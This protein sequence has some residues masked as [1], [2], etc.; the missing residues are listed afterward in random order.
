MKKTALKLSFALVLLAGMGSAFA[1]KPPFPMP[2][3][4]LFGNFCGP[5]PEPETDEPGWS[6]C[7]ID[8]GNGQCI[9]PMPVLY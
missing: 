4:S 2:C 7:V 3:F 8:A 5:A 9:V 1:A 6:V